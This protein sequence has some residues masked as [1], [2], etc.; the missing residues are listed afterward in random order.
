MSGISCQLQIANSM[1]I[2]NGG[3]VRTEYSLG[4]FI[5]DIFVK[6]KYVVEVH[7]NSHLLINLDDIS[8]ERLHNLKTVFRHQTL[9]KM[10]Y[11][12][13]GVNII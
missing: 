10:G 12:I 1:R 7:G 4:I 11:K 8:G 9:Q 3:N 2:Y 6:Q 5:V 13:I